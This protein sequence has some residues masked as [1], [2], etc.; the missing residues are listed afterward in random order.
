[1]PKT[2]MYSG[3]VPPGVAQDAA[4]PWPLDDDP[5]RS[6]FVL[7]Q[8]IPT[9]YRVDR[10]GTGLW[11]QLLFPNFQP[12]SSTVYDVTTEE[13]RARLMV[14]ENGR[15]VV[16]VV[17]DVEELWQVLSMAH[18]RS[19]LRDLPDALIRRY[20]GV[21]APLQVSTRATAHILAHVL[22]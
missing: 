19:V 5:Q 12:I 4:G 8:D 17:F 16:G 18:V 10:F 21:K 6:Y 3:L 22:R 13:G 11:A 15:R 2:I 20:P 7:S 9:E 1:M 14:S